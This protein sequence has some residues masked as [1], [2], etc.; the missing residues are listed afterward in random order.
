MMIEKNTNASLLLE[1]YKIA[2]EMSDKI[3]SR[4]DGANKLFVSLCSGL[5]LMLNV[6]QGLY[7]IQLAT[8]VVGVFLSI[9]WAS[10]IWNYKQLNSAKFKVIH[11]MERQLEYPV[12]TQEW[13]FLGKGENKKLYS[14]LTVVEGWLPFVFLVL[15]VFLGA[16]ILFN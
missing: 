12:F 4:R 6:D 3:S 11:L 5:L 7:H 2:V 10:L 15:F 14:K 8:C 1:Q 9:V 16:S 13:D